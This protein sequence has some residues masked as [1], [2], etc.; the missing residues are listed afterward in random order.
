[1]D[2]DVSVIGVLTF[3]SLSDNA[4]GDFL[5]ES[6]ILSDFMGEKIK[7][8]YEDSLHETFAGHSDLKVRLMY[9]NLIDSWYNKTGK[10]K[11]FEA[12]F[13]INKG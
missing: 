11:T 9:F 12:I 2:S 8:E 5:F 10:E 6:C 13:R 1:M 7:T 4:R 3:L